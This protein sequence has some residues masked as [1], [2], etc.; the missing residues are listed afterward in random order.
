[1]AKSKTYTKAD[2]SIVT[3]SEEDYKGIQGLSDEEVEHRAETDPDALPLSDDE[4]E[5]L[6]P[7]KNRKK[8]DND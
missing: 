1:M 3:I 8:T 4:L 5:K 2:G 6:K 7:V